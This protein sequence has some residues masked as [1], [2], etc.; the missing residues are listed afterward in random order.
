MYIRVQRYINIYFSF[1]KKNF[2]QFPGREEN[3]TFS[4]VNILLPFFYISL[5]LFDRLVVCPKE[6]KRLGVETAVTL[7][8]LSECVWC[9]RVPLN[10]VV[11]YL[12]TFHTHDE[13]A[14]GCAFE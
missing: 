3:L 5:F 10:P 12:H 6:N 4:F 7:V 13:L 11:F 8:C 14:L 2:K 1:I 9:V